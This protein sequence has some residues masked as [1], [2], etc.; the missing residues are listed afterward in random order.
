MKLFKNRYQNKTILVTGHTGFKGG[1]LCFWLKQLGAKVIGYSLEPPSQ[2]NLFEAVDLKENLIH[3]FG[4]VRNYSHLYDILASYQPDFVFHLAAQP[5]VVTSYRQPLLTYETNVMGTVNILEAVQNTPNV[6][7]VIIV[8]SDKCYENKEWTW[9]YREI[10]PMGG[11]DPYS[12]SKGCAELVFNA[13]RHSFFTS[14]AGPE[15]DIGAASVRAG[16]VIGGGDW[17]QDR[18]VPDCVRALSHNQPIKIRNPQSIRPW[19]YVLEP[20]SGYLWLGAHLLED[21]H[22]YSGSWNFGSNYEAYLT[23]ADVVK[24]IIKC[25]GEGSWSDHSNPNAFHE[26]RSLKLNCD[27]AFESLNWYGVLPI[28]KGLQLTVDWYKKFYQG[29]KGMGLYTYCAK[30]LNEYIEIAKQ[31]CL[32]WT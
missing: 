24:K 21:P 6:Q 22:Q 19:Q 20:L 28:E 31:K 32:Q 14:K 18:L 17:G 11:N 12:S 16:N 5:L 10:D 25:W 13:Y 7:G 1:W 4:D 15:R 9:G 27:K 30:Q 26:S 23:V 3:I 8:T 29:S 2:P